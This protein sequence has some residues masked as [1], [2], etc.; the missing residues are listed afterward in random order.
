MQEEANAARLPQ[1]HL[2]SLIAATCQ[3]GASEIYKEILRECEQEI[4]LS[5]RP[6]WN[7]EDMCGMLHGPG[8]QK[9]RGLPVSSMGNAARPHEQSLR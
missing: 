6:M 5:A 2:R 9:Q 3:Q 7:A 4:A 1:P 8:G